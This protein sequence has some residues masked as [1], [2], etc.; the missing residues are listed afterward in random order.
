VKNLF[1][2]IVLFLSFHSMVYSQV[3]S[4]ADI[5]PISIAKG[6]LLDYA[7]VVDNV[8]INGEDAVVSVNLPNTSLLA[9][10]HH[11]LV[12]TALT[13]SGVTETQEVDLNVGNSN[14]LSNVPVITGVADHAF[15]EGR[16]FCL[17][18]AVSASSSTGAKLQVSVNIQYPEHLD[19]GVHKIY[20][21]A[22]DKDGKSATKAGSVTVSP[23]TDS[24]KKA[25]WARLGGFLY[26]KYFEPSRLDPYM[27]KDA[28]GN[29]TTKIF[30]TFSY[31]PTL[32]GITAELFYLDIKY[33]QLS[34]DPFPIKIEPLM[35]RM[36]LLLRELHHHR[37]LWKQ[38][39]M[40]I[41]QIAM[42]GT[43]D[44]AGQ[45][46]YTKDR[47]IHSFRIP[48]S[49]FKKDNFDKYLVEALEGLESMP[50]KIFARTDGKGHLS[51]KLYDDSATGIKILFLEDLREGY[52]GAFKADWQA[53]NVTFEENFNVQMFKDEYNAVKNRFKSWDFGY[54]TNPVLPLIKQQSN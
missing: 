46:A 3:H 34:I 47:G 13:F 40:I 14:P 1:A 24:I 48:V 44:R 18:K 54:Y 38:R 25:E 2:L 9:E 26:E 8:K 23:V 36:F 20:Y 28:N 33:D 43:L 53:G 5:N 10:G 22:V 27:K 52:Y 21:T 6:E 4:L 51:H 37:F 19:P 49:I 7:T 39:K 29:V 41:V 42:R 30:K 50:T 12:F 16:L 35:G 15:S 32:H 45:T 11:K 31:S 17:A